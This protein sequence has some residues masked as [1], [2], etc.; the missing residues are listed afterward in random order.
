VVVTLTGV[1]HPKVYLAL[2]YTGGG[3][4]LPTLFNAQQA[5]FKGGNYEA[6]F[7]KRSR[8]NPHVVI[9]Q[10]DGANSIT[11]FSYGPLTYT[12]LTLGNLLQEEIFWVGQESF[13]SINR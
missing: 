2:D 5:T 9:L 11:Y 3:T 1:T 8:F 6:I 12:S 4:V 10:D 7:P 13:Y